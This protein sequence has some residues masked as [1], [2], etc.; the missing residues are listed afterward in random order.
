LQARSPG[1]LGDSAAIRRAQ[2][3]AFA[4]F[5]NFMYP[6]QQGQPLIMSGDFNVAPSGWAADPYTFAHVYNK[7][8]AWG[9]EMT[10]VLCRD[11]QGNY[12]SNCE[13]R[14]GVDLNGVINSSVDHIYI[15]KPNT[16]ESDI[17]GLT[18]VPRNYEKLMLSRALQLPGQPE[19]VSLN[20]YM[21]H[22]MTRVEY[23]VR[24]TSKKSPAC[25][26]VRS[27]YASASCPSTHPAFTGITGGASCFRYWGSCA[28]RTPT[29]CE[30]IGGTSSMSLENC[31]CGS[32]SW[33]C[34]QVPTYH[35]SARCCRA[36]AS[37]I[38]V[39]QDLDF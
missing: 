4:R 34:F 24:R 10:A 28:V 9:T 19:D 11:A 13:P 21:D 33:S 5:I 1:I 27:G 39:G 2:A 36:E 17:S 6:F 15:T 37:A 29:N 23:E 7:F 22:A 35:Y 3:D 16:F 26:D 12:R 31:S 30:L 38:E 25:I 20:R 8:T 32:F 18:L 14:N